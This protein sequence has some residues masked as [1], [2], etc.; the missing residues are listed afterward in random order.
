MFCHDTEWFY[1]SLSPETVLRDEAFGGCQ[2]E[3]V[4]WKINANGHSLYVCV[5]EC[6]V[7]M[8]VHQCVSA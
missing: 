4:C 7:S 6:G 1:V 2:L 5:S 3:A 8:R